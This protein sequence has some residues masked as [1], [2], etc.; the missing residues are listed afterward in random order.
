MTTE[1]PL[2][3]AEARAA[4][5][6]GAE[7]SDA[8]SSDGD[9]WHRRGKTWSLTKRTSDGYWSPD[10]N[11]PVNPYVTYRIIPVGHPDHSEYVATTVKRLTFKEARLLKN[12]WVFI[13][14]DNNIEEIETKGAIIHL[15][16]YAFD[17][18]GWPIVATRE[19]AEAL[20]KE[21][22]GV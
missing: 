19:E 17:K 22:P 1:Y 14:P 3:L 12:V 16:L 18:L 13:E 2:T 7:S 15:A 4:L 5:V 10:K 9:R 20:V 11:G 8:E 6:N 21:A